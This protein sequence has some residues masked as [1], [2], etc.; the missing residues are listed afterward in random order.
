MAVGDH[1][2]QNEGNLRAEKAN[3]KQAVA[4]RELPAL[5]SETVKGKLESWVL[6]LT[7]PA[8]KF[9]Q[10]ILIDVVLGLWVWLLAIMTSRIKGTFELRRANGLVSEASWKIE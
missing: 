5:N 8:G 9:L 6:S 2:K 4:G 10:R 7:K 3:I 1:D